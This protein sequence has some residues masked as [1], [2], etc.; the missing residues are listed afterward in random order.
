MAI[1]RTA[2]LRAAVVAVLA[3]SA[4]VLAAC[5]SS[6]SSSSNTSTA[7]PA[8]ATSAAS[9]SSTAS[10]TAAATGLAIGTA[11]GSAG[12]YLT[13]EKG[14]ALYLWVADSGGKSACS[15]ACAQTWPP[16]VSPGK[17][18]A[19]PGVSAADLGTI[20]RADGS[21]QVTYKGHPLYYFAADTKAGSTTGQGN[22]SFGAAWWLVGPSGTAITGGGSSGGGSYGG[23]SA[24]SS[25]SSSSGGGWG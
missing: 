9:S 10:S 25:S 8:S 4:T 1:P 17:P 13:G 24:S 11:K 21:T 18:S 19:G 3:T 6:S 2:K 23:G 14:R 12:T 5:G 20:S 15:G 22:T 7:A 16:V